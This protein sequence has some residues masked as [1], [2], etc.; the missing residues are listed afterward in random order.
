[1]VLT[2]KDSFDKWYDL[3]YP[4]HKFGKTPIVKEIAHKAYIEGMIIGVASSHNSV[5]YEKITEYLRD[6]VDEIREQNG[7]GNSQND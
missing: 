6:K 3:N 5:L 4:I 1:M 7:K 2:V